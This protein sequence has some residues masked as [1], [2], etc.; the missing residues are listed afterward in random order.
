MRA[1]ERAASL[2]AEFERVDLIIWNERFSNFLNIDSFF[3]N[4]VSSEFTVR[5]AFVRPTSFRNIMRRFFA[6][7]SV[8]R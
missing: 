2:F 5:R 8:L 1:N 3:L 4:Y 6:G 7:L